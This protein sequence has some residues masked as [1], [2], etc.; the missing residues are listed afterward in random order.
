MK[1]FLKILLFFAFLSGCDQPRHN[2]D[3]IIIPTAPVNFSGVNSG[4]DDYNSVMIVTETMEDFSLFF[5]TNRFNYGED[6][7]FAFYRCM[8]VGSFID[9]GFYIWTYFDHTNMTDSAN[10]RFNEWG[11]YLTF[12][13]D[14][15]HFPYSADRRFFYTSDANGDP[16]IF[17]LYYTDASSYP[18]Y[19]P[20]GDPINLAAINT[21][22][23][24]GYLTIHR[25][26]IPD[27]ETV[28]FMS[29]RDGNFD[30]YRAISEI[31]KSIDQSN[32]VEI[33]RVESLNSEAND[34]CPFTAGDLMVFASDREGGSGGYDLWYSTYS[35]SEWSSPENFGAEINSSYNEFRPVILLTWEEEF[36]NNMMIFSSD[37]PGGEG[38][39]DLYYVG[40]SKSLK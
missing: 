27:R 11:P 9:G 28:Y 8:L 13:L 30:L 18:E 29:D 38:G 7:D 37:R 34:K 23:D 17:C 24:D 40:I 14:S 39:Y 26:E 20:V 19:S 4:Y 33:S 36:L 10:S 15:H 12:D 6:F 35:D 1:T 5:S 2:F 21:N 16:D 25:N 3:V 22:A 32:T 31:N